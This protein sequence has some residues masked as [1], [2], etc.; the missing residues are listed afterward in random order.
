MGSAL[1]VGSTRAA[2]RG[3]GAGRQLGGGGGRRDALAPAQGARGGSRAVPH[4]DVAATV[5]RGDTGATTVLRDHPSGI[6][7]LDPCVDRAPSR[8]RGSRLPHT[9]SG[10]ERTTPDG[11]EGSDVR[12]PIDAWGMRPR[13]CRPHAR[14]VTRSV[15]LGPE[16]RGVRTPQRPIRAV[17]RWRTATTRTWLS[18]AD[19]ADDRSGNASKVLVPAVPADTLLGAKSDAGSRRWRE[20]GA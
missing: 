16:P 19:T 1:S 11:T 4:A 15:L 14:S 9:R 10:P 6:N 2:I 8:R 13:T 20:R 12:P 5:D 7:G 17:D 3:R 18:L